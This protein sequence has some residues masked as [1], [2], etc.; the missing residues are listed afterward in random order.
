M[1]ILYFLLAVSLGFLACDIIT[2][3]E[4]GL[5][6]K[7]KRVKIGPI[8]LYPTLRVSVKGR[9]VWF[10]HWVS[11]TVVLFVS[12]FFITGGILDYTFIKGL[13]VGGILQ[14]LTFPDRKKFISHEQEAL[15]RETQIV[16]HQ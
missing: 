4:S 6:E 2:H 1:H 14:G 9:V 12:I 15:L 16:K 5:R 10:H 8:Q 7:G 11:M 3:P 13:L